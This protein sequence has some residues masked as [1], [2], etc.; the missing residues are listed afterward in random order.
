[1]FIWDKW[2]GKIVNAFVAD[3][4]VVNCV[5]PHPE[6]ACENLMILQYVTLCDAVL[7]PCGSGLATSGIEYDIKLWEPTSSVPCNLENISR[8]RG[9]TLPRF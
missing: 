9:Q 5:Q 6:A 2:T 3:R 4:R 8:V 1:M 7:F